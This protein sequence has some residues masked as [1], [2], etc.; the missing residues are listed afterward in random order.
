MQQKR[1]FN[2][3]RNFG[4]NQQQG[5][6]GPFGLKNNQ[7]RII[8]K[9]PNPFGDK[10][11]KTIDYLDGKALLKFTNPQAKILPKRIN[12]TTAYQQRQITKAIKYARHLALIPFVGQDLA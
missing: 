10:N 3:N 5:V 2:K 6:F 1:G 9:K 4:N 7:K 11:L 8:T 12:G